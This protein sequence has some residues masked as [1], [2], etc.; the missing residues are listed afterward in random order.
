VPA[1]PR[2]LLRAC[3]SAPAPSCLP[4][5]ARSFVPASPRLV[6]SLT[7][8]VVIFLLLSCALS[9]LLGAGPA[10]AQGTVTGVNV[11]TSVS[12]VTVPVNTPATFTV[13]STAGTPNPDTYWSVISGPS[14]K[15]TDY[16]DITPLSAA[17]ATFSKTYSVPGTYTVP[18][19][20]DVFYTVQYARGGTAI[21]KG[22]GTA[23]KPVTI[24]VIG[25]PISG[26]NDIHW[27]CNTG[28]FI[29]WGYLSAASGQPAGTTYSWSMA[30][31]AQYVGDTLPP[32]SAT[33]TYAGKD[34]GSHDVGDVKATVTY[35]LNGVTAT[36]DPYPITVH[37]P[38]QFI[39]LSV[40]PP[41][42]YR[43]PD[44]YGFANQVLH[45]EVR[46]G[47][48]QLVR[49]VYWDES[50]KTNGNVPG[51]E[52]PHVGGPLDNMGRSVDTFTDTLFPAPTNA[53]V[54]PVSGPYTHSYWATDE[55]GGF[56]GGGI[57]SPIQVYPSVLYNVFGVTGN[58]F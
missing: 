53:G 22:T 54:Y 1:S 30:G 26:T 21:I 34:T 15:W 20:C 5:R 39:V 46:D 4:L 8:R 11:T 27:Y 55:G 38:T 45:F 29:D 23:P 10:Y 42:Q 44:T 50:W 58:G 31:N 49:N 36:S 40:D 17:S 14:Y 37:A 16:Y 32:T 33:A 6:S 47:V 51:F 25:G 19:S 12:T 43:G 7:L 24:Y 56:A 41:T 18:V 3:L 9:M 13:T 57:G 2:P 28:K 48:N 35:S 52:P